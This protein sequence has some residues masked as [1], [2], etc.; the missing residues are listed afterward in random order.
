MATCLSHL[1]VTFSD[2]VIS[3]LPNVTEM[4][5]HWRKEVVTV[6]TSVLMSAPGSHDVLSCPAQV[7][8]FFK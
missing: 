6:V 5:F 8:Y 2:F 4:Q 7:S 3:P 1:I